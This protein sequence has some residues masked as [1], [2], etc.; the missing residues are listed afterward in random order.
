M[1]ASSLPPPPWP[2]GEEVPIA[3]PDAAQDGPSVSSMC[4]HLFIPTRVCGFSLTTHTPHTPSNAEEEEE[5]LLLQYR[6][7]PG[8]VDYAAPAR[9][10]IQPL[11]GEVTIRHPLKDAAAAAA[12]ASAEAEE[13]EGEAEEPEEGSGVNRKSLS[14]HGHRCVVDCCSA[15]PF[16]WRWI[17]W[18]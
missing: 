14:F 15:C 4:S 16:V 12:A 8:T 6:F 18:L 2:A 10:R 1:A 11:S 5:L 13:G 9:Y 7:K 17:G 3:L